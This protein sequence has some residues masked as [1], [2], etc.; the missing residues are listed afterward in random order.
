MKEIL[1]AEIPVEVNDHIKFTIN[2]NVAQKL[3]LT[4]ASE[5]LFQANNIIRCTR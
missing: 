2:L 4:I 5:V 3:G 1:P